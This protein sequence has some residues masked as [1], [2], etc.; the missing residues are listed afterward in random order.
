MG[1][2]AVIMGYTWPDYGI[3]EAI[4]GELRG[5]EKEVL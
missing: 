5:T 4:A 3:D 1:K 2:V